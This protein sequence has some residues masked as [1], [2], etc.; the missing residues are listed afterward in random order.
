MQPS[1]LGAVARRSPTSAVRSGEH[2]D[3]GDD[4]G[5]SDQKQALVPLQLQLLLANAK[6]SE[7]AAKLPRP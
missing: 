4:A 7:A 5:P 3:H 1:A 2:G 6:S